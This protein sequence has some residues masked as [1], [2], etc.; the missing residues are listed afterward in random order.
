MSL[1]TARL[2]GIPQLINKEIP[3]N[4]YFLGSYQIFMFRSFLQG[5][6]PHYIPVSLNISTSSDLDSRPAAREDFANLDA[7]AHHF[8]RELS[9]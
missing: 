9:S 6:L 1:N 7:S 5:W 4:M 8:H 3:S 2:L